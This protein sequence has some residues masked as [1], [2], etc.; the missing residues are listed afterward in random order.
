MFPRFRIKKATRRIEFTKG[1]CENFHSCCP[2]GLG[3]EIL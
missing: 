1:E 3:L 2:L